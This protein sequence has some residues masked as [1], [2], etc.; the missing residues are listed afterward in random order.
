ME[1]RFCW[2]KVFTETLVFDR[3]V[4][5]SEDGEGG[6]NGTILRRKHLLVKRK[7]HVGVEVKESVT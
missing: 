4:I 5:G 7:D 3:Y 6:R 1:K 2:V